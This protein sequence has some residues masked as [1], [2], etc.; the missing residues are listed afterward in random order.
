VRPDHGPV[1]ITDPGDDWPA[2]RDLRRA[3]ADDG[4]VAWVVAPPPSSRDNFAALTEAM[5]TALGCV[6]TRPPR[7][8]GER[9][10]H[11]VLPYLRH[12]PTTDVVISEAQWL[13]EEV[14]ADVV[15]AATVAGVRLWLLVEQPMAPGLLTGLV[16]R[17]GP[18]T[19]WPTVAAYW[20]ARLAGAPD[21]VQRCPAVGDEWTSRP[22]SG[23]PATVAEH[24][25][26]LHESRARCLL[27]AARREVTAARLDADELR[28]LL[29][30]V[31]V[32][33][34]TTAD[35]VWALRDAG[36]DLY[37]AALDVVT[38]VLPGHHRLAA[39]HTSMVAG[40]GSWLQAP[41][42]QRHAVPVPMRAALARQRTVATM[43]NGPGDWPLLTLFDELPTAAGTV[44]H[45]RVHSR[46]ARPA[47]P[48]NPG[49]QGRGLATVTAASRPT[50]AVDGAD[51]RKGAPR[52][53]V[54]TRAR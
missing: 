31:E 28:R 33:A 24:R 7:A 50:G 37:L 3:V 25:C 32:D 14:I 27:A 20:D 48:R 2:L 5:L 41:D 9:H 10:M 42:G 18:L 34:D 21:R 30:A 29:G 44:S 8:Y 52:G 47:T 49:R 35:E 51:E 4:A 26:D 1:V 12:G 45:R 19:P 54:H 53:S 17:F 22:W 43:C 39:V 38:R 36:R 6:G 23:W 40:D 15:T 13:V 11:R 46:R 16:E